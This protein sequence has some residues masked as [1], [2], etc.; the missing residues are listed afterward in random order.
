MVFVQDRFD[1]DA[2]FRQSSL[3]IHRTFRGPDELLSILVS[4]SNAKRQHSARALRCGAVSQS[5]HAGDGLTAPDISTFVVVPSASGS[6]DDQAFPLCSAPSAAGLDT[7][8][9]VGWGVGFGRHALSPQPSE[10]LRK[11]CW[12]QAAV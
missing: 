4:F 8:P 12:H 7:V 9:Q 10:P 6:G 11:V 5:V 1:K 2:I 3:A